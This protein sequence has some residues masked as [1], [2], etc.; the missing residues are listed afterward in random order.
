MYESFFG[1]RERPFDL[2]PNPRF[3]LLTQGHRRALIN[4]E[5]GIA[6]RK[7][8][9][10]LLGEPGTGKTTVARA[11]MSRR[12]T[13]TTYIYLSQSLSS[14]VDLR[15]SLV[16]ALNLGPRG[17]TSNTDLILDLTRQLTS[18]S[19]QGRTVALFVD[20]AQNLSDEL[21]E[22]VRLLTNVET[23]EGK[24]LTIVLIGQPKLA[25]RLNEDTWRQLKQRVEI[26]SVLLPLELTETTA[27]IWTRVRIAGG[28]AARLFTA[29]AVRLIHERSRGIARSISVIGENALMSGFAENER[30]VTRRLVTQV[31]EELDLLEVPGA[32][33]EA[34]PP[35]SILELPRAHAV[36]NGH[37]PAQTPRRAQPAEPRRPAPE[38]RMGWWAWLRA[39]FG[40]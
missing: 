33:P 1:L 30:P 32:V 28:D 10:V 3:L 11:L 22:E 9:V 20:E 25:A 15:R 27:Y 38:A 5:L 18:L 36:T 12:D 37:R 16:Q 19:Q 39:R 31:C 14:A 17:E 6:T 7:G 13:K 4:L 8:V 2:A 21:L 34:A 40:S 29:D 26:R 35:E 24:L 23:N